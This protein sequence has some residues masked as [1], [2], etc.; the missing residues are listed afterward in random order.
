MDRSSVIKLIQVG[1]TE[2]EIGQRV[3]VENSRDV[4]CNIESISGKEWIEVGQIGM[5]P[6]F[7]ISMFC[8]DY[9][10]EMIVEIDGKRYAVYRT[11]R[12]KNE[13]LELYLER[14]AGI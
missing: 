7:K 4:F 12:A 9:E 10:N 5:N 1:Y 8:Y 14:K 2:D 13:T 11:Y 3:P 6:E